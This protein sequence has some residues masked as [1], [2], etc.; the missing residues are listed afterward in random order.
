MIERVRAGVLEQG[1]VDLMQQVGVGERLARQGLRH[2]GIYLAFNGRRHRL[3]IAAATNGL[4]ITIYGQNEVLRD[5]IDARRSA[6]L[7]L[8]FEAPAVGI[9]G[10]ESTHPVIEY[11]IAGD[12]KRLR[13]DF[14]AGCDGLPTR[15]RRR[16]SSSTACTIAGSQFD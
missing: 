7:P 10:I 11:E 3:D 6:G 9:R 2:R 4:A 16:A 12:Q 13:C 14:V 8:H 1:T 15:R 5:L